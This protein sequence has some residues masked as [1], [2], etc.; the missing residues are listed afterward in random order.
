[1][2]THTPKPNPNST[3]GLTLNADLGEGL[4]DI[5]RAIFPYLDQAN[6]AC[7]G[8]AGDEASMRRCVR[9]AM[10]F[11]VATGAHPSYPD[12]AN[13]GRRSLNIP[14]NELKASL[15]FQIEALLAI[16]HEEGAR[17]SY[18]KP[19]GA[20][21]NDWTKSDRLALMIELA[22]RF[23]LPI[24][25]A[26]GHSVIAHACQ[27]NGVV[28]LQEVFAD[29]GYRD[30][31]SLVPRNSPKALLDKQAIIERVQAMIS[32]E[33]VTTVAGHHLALPAD[34]LCI[35]SDTPDA[36]AIA[37]AVRQLIAAT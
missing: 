2:Q 35:H 32:G 15:C 24:M 7:L 25:L 20:L 3:K 33:G 23:Q 8:H 18:I 14:T 27:A 10:E 4:D 22:H 17:I 9:W 36:V 29:R 31:G 26:A 21:Y 5:D 37:K 6:I 11:R 28:Y 13:F 12:R 16:A 34:S 19:H 1:M 30:D